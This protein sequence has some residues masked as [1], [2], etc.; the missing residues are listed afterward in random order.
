MTFLKTERILLILLLLAYLLVGALFA[1]RTPAWQAPDEPAHFNYV[2]QVA[3]NG[4]CPLLE[5][6]DWDSAYLE[7]LKS[8]RFAPEL[9]DRLPTI[10]FEDHQPPLYYLLASLVFKLTNGS[11][12]ALRLLSVLIGAGVVTGAYAVGKALLP[13]QP[14][15]AL[16][17]A[18]L[19]AFLPQHV[20]MLAAVNNDSLAELSVAVTLWLTIRYVKTDRVR[21]WQLGVLVGVG[22][23]TKVSTIFL[24]GLV[25]LAIVLKW[26]IE[27][28]SEGKRRALPLA[29]LA[30]FALPVLLLGGLWWARNLSI[31]GFPD[32]FGLGRHNLVVADQTR[33]ADRI[34]EVGA[35]SYLLDGIA[36]TFRSFWGQFGWMA[37]PLQGW[38]YTLILIFLG[39][40]AAGW[41]VGW[42]RP[43]PPEPDRAAQKA[44]WLI[45]GLTA[46]AALAQYVYY[47]LEFLQLQGRYLYPGLIPVGIG[48]ALGFEGVWRVLFGDG[49]EGKRP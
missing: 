4:C 5:A 48:V 15:I 40:A 14:Q 10:Q 18:A 36:T 46:L 30:A 39:I 19:V 29:S 27:R 43:L 21:V 31:Y 49:R 45:V 28:D 47:N 41:L 24:V 22:L 11:L 20:A 13:Q 12:I 2:A 34:A 38:M 7:R 9:L 17:T 44:A 32:V 25:L 3:A 26:W 16:G 23:L 37:F 8:A 1:I 6:G 33:T 42:R 35:G